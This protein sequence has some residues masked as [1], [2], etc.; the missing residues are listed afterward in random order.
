MSAFVPRIASAAIVAPRRRRGTLPILL[1]VAALALALMG[2]EAARPAPALALSTFATKCDG[3]VL[4]AKPSTSS[5]KKATLSKGIKVVAV[6]KVSGGSW[7][8]VCAGTTSRGSSWL[9]IT[10]ANGKDVKTRFGVS[11]VYAASSLFKKLYSMSYRKAACDGVNLRTSSSTSGTKKGSLSEDTKVTVIGTVSGGSWS[12]T[13]D[14]AVSGSSWYKISQVNGTSVSSLYGVSAVYGAKGLFTSLSTTPTSTPTPTPA[15]SNDPTPAPTPSPTSGYIEGIDVSHWQETID[16]AKVKA[17]GK[18]FAFIK[19][20]ESTDFLDN[21]YATNRAQAKANGIKVGAYH[22]ARPGTNTNDAVNEANWFV[23][24]AAPVSGELIPVLDLEVTGGLTDA[25]L[26]AWAKAF[27]D[28]VYAL[29][30]VRGAI[31]VSPS[32]WSNNAGNSSNL[33][34]AGYKVLWIAH[35]TTASS[36][37]TPA[38]HWNGNGWT[39]WQYTSSGTVSGISGRVDLNRYRFNDLSKVTIP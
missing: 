6:D 22:F 30:G 19:A 1:L 25:Q 26:S 34:V 7:K 11:Y 24:N 3:V 31:Y 12:T 9:K 33:A 13:C 18:K 4:R 28:R 36:P 8:T 20:T 38:N 32:F 15:P 16:W 35:W 21:K 37:T 10:V 17:A 39:F 14:G 2:L 29:T 5:T 23:K 27:L